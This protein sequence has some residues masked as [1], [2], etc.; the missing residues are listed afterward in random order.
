[1]WRLSLLV[2]L[3]YTACS[4]EETVP[5]PVFRYTIGDN[6][7]AY[8]SEAH[9][10][11]HPDGSLTMGVGSGSSTRI[12]LF[13]P[14]TEL[15]E[16]AM[17]GTS[18]ARATLRDARLVGSWGNT[19]LRPE[20][21]G[22]VNIERYDPDRAVISGSFSFIARDNRG[23]TPLVVKEGR[24]DN[25]RVMPSTDY[26]SGGLAELTF[27]ETLRR[28]AD[29]RLSVYPAYLDFQISSPEGWVNM[30]LPINLGTGTHSLQTD[31]NLLSVPYLDYKPSGEN[32]L[33][34]V[35][36]LSRL[37]VL[38]WEPERGRVTLTFTGVVG[39]RNNPLERYPF[40]ITPLHLN[41]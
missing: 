27:A 17:S 11:L 30:H 36:S 35:D 38:N 37:E 24:F 15:R 9:A 39:D 41:W 19:T 1:M 4:T 31:R 3:L 33:V 26:F 40:S 10:H 16:Y 2:L 34:A 20:R 32:R 7:S 25:L 21:Q 13:V 6:E 12:E 8:D 18:F 5:D 14:G 28:T 29:V 22:F 23:G